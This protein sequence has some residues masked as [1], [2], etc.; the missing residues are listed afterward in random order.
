MALLMRHR[1]ALSTDWLRAHP[2]IGTA[3]FI[4]ALA[5]LF[6]RLP[7]IPYELSDSAATFFA[8][9]LGAA[10][11]VLGASWIAESKE[12]R[13]RRDARNLIQRELGALRSLFDKLPPEVAV[14]QFQT[15][16]S[17]AN[18]FRTAVHKLDSRMSKLEKLF[19]RLGPHGFIAF[20]DLV[21]VL[22]ELKG[23][24]D[25]IG[26]TLANPN[27]HLLPEK[28]YRSRRGHTMGV[29]KKLDEIYA[30]L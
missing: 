14:Q 6:L 8:T 9:A 29:V 27:E 28:A 12:H 10:I 17:A 24:S 21:K 1:L 15:T 13:E 2:W 7:L 19:E 18:N 20:A 5:G 3:F 23:L 25:L 26:Q 16:S 4:G 30:V 11:T 22:S